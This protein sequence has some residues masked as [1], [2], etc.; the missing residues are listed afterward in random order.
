MPD[1]PR[2]AYLV[3]HTHWDR[4][5]YRTF[6]EFRA[7]FDGVMAEVLARLEA[8]GAFRHFLLDGQALILEDHLAVHPE[9]AARVR[10]LVAAGRLALGPWY[11]LSDEL[12]VSGEATLRNLL[13]GHRAC[14]PLGGAQRAG[15]LPDS[16]GHIAQMPQILRLAGIDSFVFTR[17]AG[18]EIADLGWEFRWR[19]PDGSEVLA[20]NQCGGYCNAAALG[21]AEIWHAHTPRETDPSRAAEQVRDL[22]ARMAPRARAA[23]WLLGNGCDHL[24]PQRDFDAMLAALEAAF[25]EVAFRHGSL[26]DY[27]AALRAED[28]GLGVYEGELLAGRDHLI[29]S[30]VWS[31]RLYLKRANDECQRLLAGLV[32]PLRAAL[33]FAHGVDYPRALIETAWKRLLENHP[34]DSICGCSTDAVHRQMETRFA[35]V[36]ELAGQ[37]AADGL[38]ALTPAFGRRPEGDRD[39][40]VTVFNPLPER[41]RALVERVVVLQPLGYDLSRLRLVDD[42]GRAVPF[43]VADEALAE[44]FWGIDWRG[45]T[46]GAGQRVRLDA[47]RAAFPGR[48]GRGEDRAGDSDRFLA[49]QFL[50]EDLPALGHAQFRLVEGDGPPPEAPRRVRVEDGDTLVS[51]RLRVRL[52]P[53]GRIDL[54]DLS[55][56]AAYPGLNLLE[57]EADVGDE[58]DFCAADEPDRVVSE[59]LPGAVRVVED[60]GLRAI[61]EAAFDWP[62][63]AAL[64]PDRKRRAGERA[65][66]PVRVRVAL[67]A[68]EPLA[69]VTLVFDN[70][71]EDHRLR[72]RFPVPFAAET[73]VSDGHFLV[74]ERPLRAPSGEGWAQP[75]PNAYPQQDFSLLQDGRRGLAVLARGLPE[76]AAEREGEGTVLSL[77]LLRAVGWLSRDDFPSRNFA[78]AGPT[79]PTP[80]AQCP[81][82]QVCRYAL[83]PFAGDWLA[84]GVKGASDRW[85]A[86]LPTIQGVAD[87]HVPGGGGLLEKSD[88]R[89]AVTAVKRCEDRDTLLVRLVNLSGERV[90]ERLAAGRPVRGAW[91]CD[92]LETRGEAL[93]VED[94]RVV[95]ADLR[96]HEILGV[97]IAFGD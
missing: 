10:A 19:A 5:W 48:F 96:P 36:G 66:C 63:P 1:L 30:G 8:G 59:G 70:R 56:G 40:V 76:V 79:L 15:Y 34:H 54:T 33:H 78:N 92:A 58:Y 20:V 80:G 26:A 6:Q 31:A 38:A 82:E 60:T 18:D 62:L 91:R 24:P 17:G 89:A 53:D 14:A 16:F 73:L 90:T 65:I 88:P 41:R 52:H 75:W 87:G 45:M 64:A 86:P 13:L 11:V 9:D 84:A 69:D 44:R 71:V 37:L 32:E 93:P 61:L 23:T 28:P 12:L 49:V 95:A 97:E 27:L 51:E 74:H 2:T 22:F 39:T 81:G 35:E 94:G 7:R 25:P 68:G 50:A 55:A 72:A 77:T 21:H 3:S 43:R 57:D 83:L 46:G 85:R 47:Y 4:E 29:L 67:T 42:A